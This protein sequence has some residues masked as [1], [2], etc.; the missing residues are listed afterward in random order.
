MRA[1]AEIWKK[2]STS[3]F[4]ELKARVHTTRQ[5]PSFKSVEVRFAFAGVRGSDWTQRHSDQSSSSLREKS[6]V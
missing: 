4:I 3:L 1:I 5:G 2:E 6:A